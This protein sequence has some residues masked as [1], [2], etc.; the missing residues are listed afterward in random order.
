MTMS[1]LVIKNFPEDLHEQLKQQARANHRSMTKEVTQLIEAS[2]NAPRAKFQLPPPLKL[3]SDCVMSPEELQAAITD[4]R[5]A[6]Y[7]S[8]EDLNRYMD[9]LRTDRDE[10]PR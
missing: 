8:L 10:V 2:V 4:A 9:E 7:K 3:K 6:H 1:T 5:Y